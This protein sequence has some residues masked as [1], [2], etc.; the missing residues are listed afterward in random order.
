MVIEAERVK[1]RALLLW[2]ALLRRLD[3]CLRQCGLKAGDRSDYFINAVT[4]YAWLGETEAKHAALRCAQRSSKGQRTAMLLYLA[5][6]AQDLSR[7]VSVSG[8]HARF[9]G[10]LKEVEAVIER[11]NWDGPDD[12]DERQEPLSI[13]PEYLTALNEADAHIFERK[14][15]DLF[16]ALQR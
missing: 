16:K 7:L 2:Q 6:M 4:V 9:P 1:D 14:Y 13:P 15:P 11:M 5:T 8:D 3:A 10:R 12:S